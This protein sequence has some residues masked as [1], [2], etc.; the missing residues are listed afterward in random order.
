MRSRS[1]T[2]S[3]SGNTSGDDIDTGRCSSPVSDAGR[4]LPRD[5]LTKPKEENE[6]LRQSI[7]K[8]TRQLRE[9]EEAARAREAAA[10]ARLRS[11][12]EPVDRL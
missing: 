1:P 7:S 6:Q 12:E 10:E 11:L 4:F 5:E 8:L 9:Q 2:R 3:L